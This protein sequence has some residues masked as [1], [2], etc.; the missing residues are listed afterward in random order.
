[1]RILHVVR[2][3]GPVGGM[4]RYVWEITRELHNLGH[5]IEVVCEICLADKP[6]G[7]T[8]HELGVIAP[9]PR[10]VSLLRFGRR[11]NSWLGENPHP[12]RLIHSHE[13][14][15]SH[16]ITTFHGPPFASVFEKPFWRLLSIRVLMQLYLERRELQTARAIAPNSAIISRMLAHYYP[17][18]AVKLTDPVEPGVTPGAL[19]EPRN[20]PADGGVIGFLGKEWRRK[21][22]PLA[23]E[24]VAHL[25]RAR[26]EIELWVIGPQPEEIQHLFAGWQGGYRLLGWREQSYYAEFD[27]LLHPAKAEPYGMVISEAM[28]ARVP[29]VV[30]DRCGA[31]AQVTPDAGAI[32]PLD[33]SAERWA[34]EVEKQLRRSD[35]PPQFARGWDDVA[36]EYETIYRQIFKADLK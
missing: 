7:I 32:V 29:V 36:R 16:H 22:L 20:V 19:R 31:A 26:P 2:R 28:A 17:Q 35:A 11:V 30:S 14:L 6:Q 3:Y 24:I 8:V 9:R 33:A 13:R 18:F 10:W 27:V 25:R 4:E 12:D 34:D 21:G 1:M 15:N 5:E 23:V